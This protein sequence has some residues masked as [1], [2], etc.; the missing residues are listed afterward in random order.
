MKKRCPAR[1]LR[2]MEA[3]LFA[4]GEPVGVRDAAKVL[5][6]EEKACEKLIRQ[7]MRIYENTKSGIQVERF[8]SRYQMSTR[9]DYYQPI[10]VLYETK[11]EIRLTDT[12][13]ETLSI[14]VYRQPV[15][16]QEVSDIR[17][18]ASDAVVGRLIQLGLVE[19][20]GRMRAPGRPILLKT[21]DRFLRVFGLESVRDLPHLPK[22]E[23]WRLSPLPRPSCRPRRMPLP[24]TTAPRREASRDPRAD[25]SYR[26]AK[27][28]PREPAH[29]RNMPSKRHPMP[30]LQPPSADT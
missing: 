23:S 16:R 6:L 17:G 25:G 26:R 13:L 24:D 8:E 3:L 9:P 7:L 2:T 15:T 12:Q 20:A 22:L 10:S 27:R 28:S 5:G 29:S 30:C 4:S 19:E 18:V 11:K 14:I 21:T 1:E